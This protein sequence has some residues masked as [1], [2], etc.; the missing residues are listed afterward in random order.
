MFRFII[1]I[2]YFTV[3]CDVKT[4][5][6]AVAWQGWLGFNGE[7]TSVGRFPL[8]PR[9]SAWRPAASPM[10]E[11]EDEDEER[12]SLNSNFAPPR[13]TCGPSS[14]SPF[15]LK[16]DHRHSH[17][18]HPQHHHHHHKTASES[19]L[20]VLKPPR[21]TTTTTTTTTKPSLSL[22]PTPQQ[23]QQ[24]SLSVTAAT[25]AT[26]GGGGEEERGTEA[27]AAAV[28]V[29]VAGCGYLQVPPAPKRRHSWICG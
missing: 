14:S 17:H 21:V 1:L 3:T 6:R 26:E 7:V 10:T 15:T 12:N 27:A 25:A 18:H 16:T 28:T 29:S 13:P 22:P 9:R 19:H 11:E 24:P 4:Q 8:P 20:A 2:L 5:E 23:Q